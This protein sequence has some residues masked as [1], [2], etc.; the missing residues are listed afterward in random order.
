MSVINSRVYSLDRRVF[1]LKTYH[2][3]GLLAN[4][5]WQQDEQ[6]VEEPSAAPQDQSPAFKEEHITRKRLIHI[7]LT[8]Y[9]CY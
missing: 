3:P 8:V 9:C 1:P 7:F 5:Q 6:S 4:E 2:S